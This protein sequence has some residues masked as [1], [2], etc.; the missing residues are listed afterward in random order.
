MRLLLVIP[1]SPQ[2]NQRN[3]ENYAT[4]PYRA[5]I[6]RVCSRPLTAVTTMKVVIAD[7]NG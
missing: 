5:A 6:G 1:F 4:Q 7:G 2:F 3:V